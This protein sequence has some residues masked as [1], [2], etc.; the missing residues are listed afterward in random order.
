M[1]RSIN[2]QVKNSELAAERVGQLLGMSPTTTVLGM[3][4]KSLLFAAGREGAGDIYAA[5]EALLKRVPLNDVEH[6]QQRYRDWCNRLRVTASFGSDAVPI[7]SK[8]E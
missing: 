8:N 7:G 2:P 1:L 4:T 6:A 5:P 3:I